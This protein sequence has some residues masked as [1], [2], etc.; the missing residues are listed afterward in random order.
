MSS[1]L[2]M[3]PPTLD[4]SFAIPPVLILLVSWLQALLTPEDLSL[5]HF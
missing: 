1:Y 3:F 4:F 2:P 5:P